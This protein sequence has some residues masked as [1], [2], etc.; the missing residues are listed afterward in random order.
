M[1]GK[2]FALDTFAGRVRPMLERHPPH[3]PR[4]CRKAQRRQV[5]PTSASTPT[6]NRFHRLLTAMRFPVQNH[7]L[8]TGVVV[9][10]Q[11]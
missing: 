7:A 6:I 2:S 5:A 8:L 1:T 4:C 10:A 9:F 3:D 11:R